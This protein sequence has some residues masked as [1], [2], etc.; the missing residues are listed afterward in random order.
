MNI[1]RPMASLFFQIKRSIPF[2]AR[3]E[4]KISSPSVGQKLVSLYKDSNDKEVKSMIED[5]MSRAGGN[6]KSQLGVSTGTKLVSA[7]L[8]RASH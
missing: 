7:I 4:M 8:R 3:D 5:F 1:D 6:W 2:E